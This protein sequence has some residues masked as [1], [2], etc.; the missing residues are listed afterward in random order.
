M[1]FSSLLRGV[2]VLADVICDVVL[3]DGPVLARAPDFRQVDALFRGERDCGLGR[4][5]TLLFELVEV[6]QLAFR[7]QVL[8]LVVVHV[9]ENL[10][11]GNHAT[12]REI[13]GMCAH[14]LHLPNR[15]LTPP[16]L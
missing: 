15:H 2:A 7:K 1:P 10:A 3:G 16:R 6:D 12:A 8:D 11:G 4:V 5:G 9:V 14:V 13:L